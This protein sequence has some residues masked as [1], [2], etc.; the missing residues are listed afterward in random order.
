MEFLD[1]CN[2]YGFAIV[3]AAYILLRIEPA[4]KDLNK[5]VVLL[6]IIVATQSGMDY[7][8]VKRKYEGG[9]V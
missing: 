5:S 7:D 8:D 3:V 9:D 4:I 2:S 1:W 6:S